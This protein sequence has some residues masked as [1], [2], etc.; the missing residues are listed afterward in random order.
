[1]SILIGILIFLLMF[2]GTGKDQLLGSVIMALLGFF[3][4]FISFLYEKKHNR[5]SK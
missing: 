5:E 4:S 3:G 1:M 2:I